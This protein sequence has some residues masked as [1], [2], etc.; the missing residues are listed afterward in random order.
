MHYPVPREPVFKGAECGRAREA[1]QVDRLCVRVG[2][3]AIEPVASDAVLPAVV[4][5]VRVEFKRSM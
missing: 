3:L 5:E 4:A 2:P 1:V